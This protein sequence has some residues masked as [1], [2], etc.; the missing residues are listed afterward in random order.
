MSDGIRCMQMR[1]G[2]SKGAYFLASDLPAWTAEPGT[3]CCCGSWAARRAADRRHRRRP[4][5]DQQ[6]RGGSPSATTPSDV[7]YLFLQVVV[8]QPIVTDKQNCGNILAGVG[9][10]AV[11]RGLVAAQ[12]EQTSVRIR[13]VNTD[14]IATRHVPDAR[15]QPRL[16]RRHRRSTGARYRPRRSCS[17]SKTTVGQRVL[18]DRQRRRQVR[19]DH[20]H[21][22]R[23]RHARRRGARARTSARLATSPPRSSRPTRRSTRGGGAT[24]RSR[25]GDG[26]RRRHR[27]H[28]PEGHARRRAGGAAAPSPPGPS[29]R[30]GCTTPSVCSARSGRDRGRSPARSAATW[31]SCRRR[32]AN[33]CS[34]EHPTGTL[35]PSRSNS[36][37]RRHRRRCCAPASCA[38]P[39]SF[40]TASSSRD[41]PESYASEEPRHDPTAATT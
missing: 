6:G 14:S 28:R 31:P 17:T 18:P 2:T 39:A 13:M 12:S 25:Q 30:T 33:L 29:S 8:D 16:H 38:P 41:S 26:P 24:P 37:P 32:A 10:F 11:E 5:A 15:R 1:G 3:T 7:D 36:T 19:R 27:H 34:I 9:P 4:P 40:S 23:Q 20:G 35:Q 21:L 22:R